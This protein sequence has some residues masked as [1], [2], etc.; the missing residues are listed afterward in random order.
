MGVETALGAM[1]A[2]GANGA[3]GS[4]EYWRV[5]GLRN[6]AIAMYLLGD[7][8]Q[9]EFARASGVKGD[10]IV[11][12]PLDVVCV[13]MPLCIYFVV[14]FLGSFWMGRRLGADYGKTTTITFTAASD[15]F[16]LAI[17]VAISV[18]GIGSGVAFAAV[19]GPLIEVPVL[20]GLVN[21]ALWLRRS[22]FRYA[23]PAAGLE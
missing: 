22:Y 19:I 10:Y 9:G 14:M 12:L 4:R 6:W 20:V 2:Q 7:F 23:A 3:K 18:F 5:R 21:V 17:A 8:T 1:L 15:N 16:E 13:A 11:Q